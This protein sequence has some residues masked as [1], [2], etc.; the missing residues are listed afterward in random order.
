[1]LIVETSGQDDQGDPR[2]LRVSR[3]TLPKM[4]PDYNIE[5]GIL[6]A[7]AHTKNPSG[8]ELKM[9]RISAGPG[10]TLGQ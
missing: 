4:V 3:N 10:E 7:A 1:M 6:S 9:G 5:Q 8:A 2:D